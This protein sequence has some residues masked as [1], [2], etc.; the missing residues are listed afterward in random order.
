MTQNLP[1]LQIKLKYYIQNCD[2]ILKNRNETLAIAESC[3]GGLLSHFF[4]NIPG[5]S[6]YFLT[7]IV[8]YSNQAKILYTKVD[9]ALIESKGAVSAEVAS[10]L[11]KGVKNGIHSNYGIGITGIAGPGGGS[12]KKPVGTVYISIISDSTQITRNYHFTNDR[13]QNKFYFAIEAVKLLE[14]ILT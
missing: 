10:A 2:I 12:I 4:T 8:V 3:T 11:A 14:L 13:L 7:S 1:E 5:A 6:Q 9:P